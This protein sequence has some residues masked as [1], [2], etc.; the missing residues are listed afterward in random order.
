MARKLIDINEALEVKNTRTFADIDAKDTAIGKKSTS[1]TQVN[2]YVDD[3]KLAFIDRYCKEN[4]R[5]RNYFLNMLLDKF[6]KES[7]QS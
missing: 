6:I 4:D 5:S 1:K 3:E 2:I 7:E